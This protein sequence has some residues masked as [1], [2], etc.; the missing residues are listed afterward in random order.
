MAPFQSEPEILVFSSALLLLLLN[1]QCALQQCLE[2]EFED[3]E[4]FLPKPTLS[5]EIS[6]F[7]VHDFAAASLHTFQLWNVFTMFEL[8]LCGSEHLCKPGEVKNGLKQEFQNEKKK[9]MIVNCTFYFRL[10][11]PRDAAGG[12]RLQPI[13][14]RR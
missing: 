13:L 9:S 8:H 5:T 2:V 3:L 7:D 11:R 12:S 6:N 10:H 14:H 4:F 1:A